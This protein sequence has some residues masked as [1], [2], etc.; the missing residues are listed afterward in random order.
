MPRLDWAEIVEVRGGSLEGMKDRLK[1]D[2]RERH[3]VG[4]RG[5]GRF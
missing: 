3:W 2:T 1:R 4:R 5:Q